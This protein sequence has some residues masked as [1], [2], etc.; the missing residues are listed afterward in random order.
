MLMH[1]IIWGFVK[2]LG[3]LKKGKYSSNKAKV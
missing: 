3:T 1:L 2:G